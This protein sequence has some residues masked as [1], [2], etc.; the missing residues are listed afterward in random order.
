MEARRS[1]RKSAVESQTPRVIG[2][3]IQ[4][5][6]LAR[7]DMSPRCQAVKNE[8][9]DCLEQC[10]QKLFGV[11]AN[12]AVGRGSAAL[13]ESCCEART[14]VRI[15][16]QQHSEQP[17]RSLAFPVLD[18]CRRVLRNKQTNH[19]EAARLQVPVH[20]RDGEPLLGTS[21]IL[22]GAEHIREYTCPTAC[23]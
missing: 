8:A 6:L 3:V 21:E 18:G 4:C 9:L 13:L 14:R 15:S 20:P 1:R 12:R 2:S 22:H 17:S 19:I 16:P 23:A 7:A 5:G 11:K 10:L